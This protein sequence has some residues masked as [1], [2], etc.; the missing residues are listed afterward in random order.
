MAL[1]VEDG[2]I[3]ANANTYID[4]AFLQD[5]ANLRGL[6][7]PPISSDVEVLI[8]KGADYVES[9]RDQFKGS[10]VSSTQSMQWPRQNVTIDGFSFPS[11]Q[12][13]GEL[14]NAQAQAAIEINQGADL[15]AN[16]GQTVKREKVD[17]IEV[18]YMDGSSQSVNYP[19]VDSYLDS[20]LNRSGNSGSILF[21][22]VR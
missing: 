20:L 14:K 18:E 15:Q 12:I 13:P 4:E 19:K 6:E 1:I 2:S 21:G 16:Q 8:I 17:V 5:Y 10:K 3:V 11:D 7:L 22:V 9:F